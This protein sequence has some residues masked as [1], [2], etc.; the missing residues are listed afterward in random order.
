MLKYLIA[1]ALFGLVHAQFQSGIVYL[2]DPTGKSQVT[3]NVTFTKTPNGIHV[4]GVVQG[5]AP[6][7]HGFHVHDLGNIVG[8]C[9]ATSGHFNP[10][11]KTH[12]APE[13][14]IRHVGD[15][16]NIVADQ[17]GVAKIDIVDNVIALN[18][19]NGIIGRG[20]VVHEKA[21]D[22]GK[23][24]NKDSLITGNAGGRVA[25]GVIGV[26]CREIFIAFW[27]TRI[28]NLNRFDIVRYNGLI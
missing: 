5:L 20:V 4:E 6:G 13:D 9:T 22:L 10:H 12:G 2:F 15:L 3:G 21:D 7:L 23:G 18:G 14:S 17:S 1:V 28:Y 8:G 11:K 16:G 19:Q 24:G 26:I 25:C 27:T